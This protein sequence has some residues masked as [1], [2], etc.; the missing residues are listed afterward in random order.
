[1][2]QTDKKIKKNIIT[3]DGE[4]EFQIRYIRDENVGVLTSR[5]NKSYLILDSID[6]WYDLIQE[7]YPSKQKCHCKNDYFKLCFNYIPR[8]GTNDYRAVELISYCTE[9]GKQRKISEIDIDYSPTSQ[10]FEKPITFCEQPKI[11]YKT[12][13]L[14]GY[15]KEEEFGDLIE[16][17]LQKRLWIYCWYWNQTEKKRHIKQM[18]TGELKKFLFIEKERYLKI[19]FSTESLDEMFANCVSDSDGIYVDGDVWRKREIIMLNAPLL[20]AA[21]GA[22]EFYSLDF[23]SEYIE[24]GNVK[25]KAEAFCRLIE[26]ILAYSHEKLK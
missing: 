22:G 5:S 10:L 4:D 9:C 19:Y 16:F 1:M 20:V 23:C 3:P 15:W 18:T 7:K 6:F 14:K 2:F 17:L 12:Y 21:A 11:K 24:A 26:E 8:I 13:S 25:V